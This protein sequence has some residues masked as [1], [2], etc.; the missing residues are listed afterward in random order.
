MNS[1]STTT[2]NHTN[3]KLSIE[4]LDNMMYQFSKE[5][6][7]KSWL[8]GKRMLNKYLKDKFKINFNL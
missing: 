4:C 8:R 6:E 3:P 1:F 5:N 2:H 7:K